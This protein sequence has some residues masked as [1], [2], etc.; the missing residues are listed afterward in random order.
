MYMKNGLAQAVELAALPLPIPSM[1]SAAYENERLLRFEYSPE[2][3]ENYERYLRSGREVDVHYL[4]IK[5]DIENVSRCNFRCTMCQVSDWVKGQ[6]ANDMTF[7]D[8][9]KLI[10]EQY[11]L[12]EIKI[13]GMG[14]PLMGA[15]A[16]FEMIRHARSKHI[17]VRTITNASLLHLKDNY[18]KLI[19][20]DPN[21]VQI[22]IDGATKETFEKIRRGSVFEI[23]KKNCKLINDYCRERNVARTKMWTVVQRDNIHELTAL[24]DLAAEVGF[25]SMVFSLNVQDW[26]QSLWSERVA[27]IS[28]ENKFPADIAAGLI[29]RG[30]ERGVTVAFWRAT[31]KFSAEKR[32]TLCPWPFERAYVS[33]D[34][35]VVPCCMIANPEVLDLGDARDFSRVWSSES[36]RQFR[37]DHIAG[38]IP[39]ACKG[40]YSSATKDT[41]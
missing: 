5:L 24:V 3:R 30:Q 22:S 23:V 40:C 20:S 10:D 7:D 21:E 35:R 6:R 9:K 15:P 13:Q 41:P 19:D 18:R 26:G 12:V 39:A 8:F 33:S 25:S 36:M 2:C 27:N 32:E 37:A 1:G 14:E 28:V 29:E 38:R 34:L 17:W 16:I 4:P 31:S 11:G